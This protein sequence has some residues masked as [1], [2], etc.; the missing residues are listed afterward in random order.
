MK[1]ISL[2]VE[3]SRVLHAPTWVLVSYFVQMSTMSFFGYWRSPLRS[4]THIGTWVPVSAEWV[5]IGGWVGGC[6]CVYLC[7]SVCVCV[8]VC[9]RARACACVCGCG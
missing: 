7:L 5:G 4:L 6:V 3:G 9:V 2:A 1:G 8:C